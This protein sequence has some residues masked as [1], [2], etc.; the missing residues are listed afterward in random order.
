VRWGGRAALALLAQQQGGAGGGDAALPPATGGYAVQLL[1][2]V[3][4]LVGVCVAAWVLLRWA[5]R[6]G[7][8]RAPLGRNVRVLERVVLDGRRALYLVQVGAKVLLIGGTDARLATLAELSADELARAPDGDAAHAHSAGA[9]APRARFLEVLSRLRGRPASG[10]ADVG[11]TPKPARP[12][13]ATR[14][15]ASGASSGRGVTP[16]SGAGAEGSPP[17]DEVL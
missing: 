7:I 3:V 12:E 14:A 13:S 10:A 5:A 4:V 16:G 17:G 15:E 9:Q 2:S 8:G 1:Q 6:R 11:S